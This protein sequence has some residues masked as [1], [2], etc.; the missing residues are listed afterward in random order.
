MRKL[1]RQT[2]VGHRNG[3]ERGYIIYLIL[4]P[5]RYNNC[6]IKKIIESKI[7]REYVTIVISVFWI[8]QVA[9]LLFRPR[10]N[11]LGHA[12][13]DRRQDKATGY[14]RNKVSR[15]WDPQHTIPAKI[16]IHGR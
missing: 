5:R 15:P 3:L 13:I 16:G 11:N 4:I 9:M 7:S 10:Q 1:A 8:A 2:I 12:V 6:K 14:Q